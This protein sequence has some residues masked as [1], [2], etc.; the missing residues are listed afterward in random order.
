MR[1]YYLI[2]G[3]KSC[4]TRTSFSAVSANRDIYK[5]VF[6]KYMEVGTSETKLNF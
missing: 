3:C 5:F 6:D 1:I 2:Q 4:K